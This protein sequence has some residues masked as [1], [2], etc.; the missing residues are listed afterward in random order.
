MQVFDGRTLSEILL[1]FRVQRR[2]SYPTDGKQ[3]KEGVTQRQFLLTDAGGW[4]GA[5]VLPPG[6]CPAKPRS[7]G[8]MGSDR[9]TARAPDL[10]AAA[11]PRAPPRTKAPQSDPHAP[12][13]CT[14]RCGDSRRPG[15]AAPEDPWQAVTP[16][17]RPAAYPPLPPCRSVPRSVPLSSRLAAQLSAG[18]STHAR[19][20]PRPRR[21]RAQGCPPR[22]PRVSAQRALG[23]RTD[24]P[25]P[26]G[27][28]PRQPR[29]G[30]GAE[31]QGFAGGDSWPKS[32]VRPATGPC[33]EQG[34]GRQETRGLFAGVAAPPGY[35]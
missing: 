8:A 28:S 17:A 26:G 31:R 23:M 1:Q 30:P 14:P 7:A 4:Q 15:S 10:R 18:F 2:I 16:R 9:R 24:A 5:P 6:E 22:V 35:A 21:A 27:G 34:W 13:L 3:P 25:R 32:S 12:S 11:S 19:T 29:T 20:P 33:G